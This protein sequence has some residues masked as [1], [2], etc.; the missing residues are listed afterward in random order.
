MNHPTLLLL[1][2]LI[3]SLLTTGCKT[4]N[5]P[6]NVSQKSS[7][8]SL[9]SG[10][11]W[12]ARQV[13]EGSTVVYTDGRTDNLYPGY[14]AYEQHFSDSRVNLTEYSGAAFE[15]NWE[16]AENGTR[17]TLIF[18]SLNPIP[19]NTDGTME[20]DVVSFSDQEVLL[21]ATK[22]NLKTGGTLNAYTLIPK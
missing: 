15:G 2:V 14:R 19:T 12:K 17:L 5:E 1:S 22:V 7:L 20:F 10:K 4:T 8:I 6:T 21:N 18:R 3:S 11:S 16:I 13:K 9:L